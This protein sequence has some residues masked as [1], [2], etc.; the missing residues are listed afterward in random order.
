MSKLHSKATIL[1]IVA[2]FAQECA[3]AEPQ[4][5]PSGP[6][7][8]TGPHFLPGHVVTTTVRTGVENNEKSKVPKGYAVAGFLSTTTS[9]LEGYTILDYK[10]LVEG[11]S[12]RVPTWKEDASAGMQEVYGG[13]IDSYTHLCEESRVQAFTTMVE[14]AKEIGANGVIGIHFD[15]QVMPLDKGR[16]ATG[17]VCVGTAVAVKHK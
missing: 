17:V 15:S 2:A 14:R 3:V 1:L 9:E 6:P 4:G 10:G 16:F 12:V 5:N 13:S 8:E 11:A 7:T